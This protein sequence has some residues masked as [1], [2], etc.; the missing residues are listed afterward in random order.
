MIYYQ[1]DGSEEDEGMRV[2]C[3]A[4]MNIFAIGNASAIVYT[5]TMLIPK[6]DF[7]LTLKELAWSVLEFEEGRE[8][9]GLIILLSHV[10]NLWGYLL[11][12]G[13]DKK[14]DESCTS[15]NGCRAY[16]GTITMLSAIIGA[17]YLWVYYQAE[18]NARYKTEH[19]DG[20]FASEL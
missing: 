18:M 1:N 20:A 13:D 4:L 14:K 10:L 17:V 19:C 5:M 16:V 12:E 3:R 11:E 8:I 9:A 6:I 15:T 7:G 2:M